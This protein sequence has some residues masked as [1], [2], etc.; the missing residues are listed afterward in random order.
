MTK[1]K[2][3]LKL[4]KAVPIKEHKKDVILNEVEQHMVINLLELEV[5]KVI[6]N[7]EECLNDILMLVICEWIVLRSKI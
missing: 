4:F 7:Q 1:L 2:S 5:Q 6:E 3:T